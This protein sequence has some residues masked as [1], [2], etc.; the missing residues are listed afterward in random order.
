MKYNCEAG[1]T[2]HD[3]FTTHIG[4]FDLDKIIKHK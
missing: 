1:A 4:L 2:T 3:P